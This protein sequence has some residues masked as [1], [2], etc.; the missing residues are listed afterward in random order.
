MAPVIFSVIMAI[1]ALLVITAIA[2]QQQKN[3]PGRSSPRT[4][5]AAASGRRTIQLPDSALGSILDALKKTEVVQSESPVLPENGQ[6][7]TEEHSYRDWLTQ[8]NLVRGFITA[9]LLRPPLALRRRR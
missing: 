5:P 2:S 9:E 8:D 3:P 1:A 7:E 4:A 6:L